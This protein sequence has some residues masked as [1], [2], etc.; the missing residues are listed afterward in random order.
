MKPAHLTLALQ[1]A[2]REIAARYRGSVLGILWA[3]ANPLLMLAVYTFVFGFVFKARWS[4][5]ESA[6][7]GEFALVLFS[8]LMLHAFLAEC[9]IRAPGLVLENVNYVK[10]VVFPLHALVWVMVMVGLFQYGVSLLA[11]LAGLLYVNGAIP[12][13]IIFLPVV[14]V[15]LILMALG[16]GWLLASLGV[17]LRDIRHIMGI[18]TTLLLFLSTIFYPAEALPE[19]VRSYIYLNPLSFIVDQ[20]RAVM[21]WGRMPD[22]D[23]W[24]QYALVSVFVC[25]AGYM[26]FQKT[27]KGFA[28]V[29]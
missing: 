4:M 9:F 1:L 29:V 25:M 5:G 12:W 7:G 27:R 16:I 28:D 15:P 20:A 10:R 14:L 23:G 3:L 13:T 6:D 2:G 11:L 18:I 24:M 26:W 8:G 17:Y 22:W 19:L 21:V